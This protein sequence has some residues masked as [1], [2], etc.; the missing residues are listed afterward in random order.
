LANPE[1]KDFKKKGSLEEERR[2]ES[3]KDQK[4]GSEESSEA[5]NR[6]KGN[7]SKRNLVG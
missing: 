6:G 2:V 4:E 5:S 1:E 7:L 3:S